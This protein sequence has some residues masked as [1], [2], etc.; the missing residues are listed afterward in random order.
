M[1]IPKEARRESLE[2]IRG[3]RP[4]RQELLLELLGEEELTV[5]ELVYKAMERGD[6]KEYDRGYIAP[7]V[8]E[9]KNKG[10]LK[11]V[12]RRISK[13]SGVHITI[14]AKKEPPR[15]GNTRGGKQK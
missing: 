4:I 11:A 14:W 6:I 12:G 15:C 13:R 10:V 9:L 8:T 1:N 7:R 2:R 5:E 3:K